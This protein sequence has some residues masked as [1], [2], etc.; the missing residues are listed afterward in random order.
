MF[1][2]FVMFIIVCIFDMY[3]NINNE[4][5]LFFCLKKDMSYYKIVHMILFCKCSC[6]EGDYGKTD[7]VSSGDPYN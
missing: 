1:D 2:I 7:C 3:T 4:L 6:F 5:T